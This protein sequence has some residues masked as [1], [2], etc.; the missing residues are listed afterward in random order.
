MP[1]LSAVIHLAGENIASGYWTAAKKEAIFN[2][3]VLGTQSL[4]REIR[5]C[6]QPPEVFIC[7]SAIGYYGNR[8]SETLTES[9]PA[10]DGFLSQVCKSWESAA[11][12]V[13]SLGVRVINLRFG[14]VL[15]PDGGVLKKMLLPFKLGLGGPIGDGSHY[16]S[17][18]SQEDLLKV[19]LFCLEHQ[20]LSGA[21]NACSPNPVTN[22]EFA[23]TLASSLNRPAIVKIPAIPLRLALGELADEVLL[24]STRAVPEILLSAGY[25]FVHPLLTQAFLSYFHK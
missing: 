23:L 6:P 22:R 10:G 25:E 12:E 11:H 1:P 7:A 2:S 15:S 21:I 3:R 13:S 24:C 9:S 14:I 19:V 17:W 4:C 20:Q 18:I 5:G 8:G 16:V